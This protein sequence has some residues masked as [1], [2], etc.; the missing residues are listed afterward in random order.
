MNQQSTQNIDSLTKLKIEKSKLAAYCTYQEKL[1][2]LKVE[3]FKQNYS[4]ILGQTLL[5]YDKSTNTDVN[6]FLDS[7]NNL[8]AGML[9]ET[10]KSR[11]FPR[12]LL[13]MVEIWM[14]NT[15]RRS[16]K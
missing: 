2:G 4:E 12:M 16:K 5:P 14:I 6:T 9:P 10:F 3:D 11:F 13:K 1:I 8:I 15:F 7:V